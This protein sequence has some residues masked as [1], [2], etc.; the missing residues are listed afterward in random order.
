[1]SYVHRQ[2]DADPARARALMALVACPTGSIGTE[3]RADASGA[4]AMF[5]VPVASLVPPAER[6]MLLRDISFCGFASPDSYGASSWLIRR[7]AGNV[8]VDSP[9]AAAPL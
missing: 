7:E 9:R 5:P 1:L 6:E 4:V 8:L 2:P 3:P